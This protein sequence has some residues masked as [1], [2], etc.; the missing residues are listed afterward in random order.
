MHHHHFELLFHQHM[1]T[2]LEK[3]MDNC[4]S[5][6]STA[7]IHSHSTTSNH[8]HKPQHMASKDKD[9][10]YEIAKGTGKI[11][12]NVLNIDKQQRKFE[13]SDGMLHNMMYRI[14]IHMKNKLNRKSS[15]KNPDNN[16][17]YSD[18]KDIIKG[19]VNKV[20]QKSDLSK[21]QSKAIARGI[22]N[23]LV[24]KIAKEPE[25]AIVN[26]KYNQLK[27]ETENQFDSSSMLA[28]QSFFN[29]NHSNNDSQDNIMTP[30]LTKGSSST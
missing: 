11:L 2:P 27:I 29:E 22:I 12:N 7:H 13:S 16:F 18:S 14:Y 9:N 4:I 8:M 23:K 26:A 6:A 15:D 10:N 3:F 30:S 21:E 19:L 5:S 25:E 1:G 28:S 24:E 20:V 17:T